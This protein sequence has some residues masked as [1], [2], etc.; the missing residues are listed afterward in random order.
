MDTF[1]KIDDQTIQVTKMVEPDVITY[2][3]SFLKTQRETIQAQKD[4]DNAQRD[5]ELSEVDNLLA[6][7]KSL[8]IK[9]TVIPVD[10]TPLSV[11]EEVIK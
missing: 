11:V 6:K 1:E 3:I 7:A 2:D 4:R 10:V 5:T 8:G 9:E